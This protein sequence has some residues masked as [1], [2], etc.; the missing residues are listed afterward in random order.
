MKGSR[1]SLVASRQSLVDSHKPRVVC[2]RR[3]SDLGQL[4]NHDTG[5]SEALPN[6]LLPTAD[7]RL[8]TKNCRLTTFLCLLMALCLSAVTLNAA[9]RDGRWAILVVGV[10]GDPDLQKTYLNEIADLHAVLTGSLEFPRDRIAVLFDDPSKNPDLIQYKSTL[11]NL[12]VVCRNFAGRVNKDDTVFVFIDGHGNYDGKVYKLNLVGPDPTAEDLA[13]VLYSIPARRFV[14]V[15]ATNCSGGSIQAL[16]QEE[17]IVITA[18]KSGMEKN[19]T[20][21]GQYFIDAFKNNA[22]DSDK[23]GRVSIIEAFAY[24]SQKVGNYYNSEGNLQTEHPVL[25]DNG[26]AQAQSKP[27][28]ENG[29]GLLARTAFLDA[30]TRAGN[31]ENLNPEQQELVRAAQEIEKQI[32]A[33]KY[34]KGKLPE[35]EYEK[36]LE[37]LLLKLA[38][39]NA[40]LPQ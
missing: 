4:P 28:P 8:P 1:Q 12:Q 37:D 33:L 35:A 13:A 7:Y 18:T 16:S 6:K 36:R 25:D 3:E 17:R 22:A 15:N 26:D 39:I 34:A 19:Q 40:K 5:C 14:V 20:H 23:D 2:E 21:M 32:E 29:D 24:V 31:R 9:E 10:S 30:G 38:R 27:S 11:E